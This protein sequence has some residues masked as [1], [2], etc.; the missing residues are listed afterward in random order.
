MHLLIKP[1]KFKLKFAWLGTI[2]DDYCT[3]FLWYTGIPVV[4]PVVLYMYESKIIIR[5]ILS[6]L[7]YSDLLD[8]FIYNK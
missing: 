8:Y 5:I 3:S 2:E 7:Y 1:L 6:L 4:V